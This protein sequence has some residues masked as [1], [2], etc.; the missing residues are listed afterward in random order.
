M[1]SQ[2]LLVVLIFSCG[3]AACSGDRIEKA[4]ADAG[5]DAGSGSPASSEC[6]AE[7]G[8]GDDTLQQAAATQPL[9][10]VYGKGPLKLE[11]KVACP[12]DEDCIHAYADCCFEGGAV[13]RWDASAGSLD[14]ELFDKEG[15]PL[16]L[17]A[18]GD[19][20]LRQP[21]EVR[22]LWAE[23]GGYFFVRVR[24]TEAVNVPYSVDLLASVFIR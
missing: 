11:G 20:V 17:S 2:M 7:G 24:S 23:A 4:A 18:P 15:R 5:A 22:L 14:V 9:S 13:V 21:G 10:H 8:E 1:K 19:V 6:P 16:P 12:G 3:W